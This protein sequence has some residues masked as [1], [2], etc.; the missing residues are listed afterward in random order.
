MQTPS[1]F[2]MSLHVLAMLD[3]LDG[4][5]PSSALLAASVGT[6]PVLVRRL[7]GALR[8]AGLVRTVRGARGAALARPAREI[9]LLEVHSD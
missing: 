9:T 6:H 4:A 2:A 8:R 5:A 7:L 1:K 3:V